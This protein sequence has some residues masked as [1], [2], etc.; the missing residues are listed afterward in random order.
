[1]SRQLRSVLIAGGSALALAMAAPAS[2]TDLLISP[3][4]EAE[5][6]LGGTTGNLA[7]WFQGVFGSY[8][9]EGGVD[10]S[11]NEFD[12]LAAGFGAHSRV[13]HD[14]GGGQGFQLEAIGD[15]HLSMASDDDDDDDDDAGA[16]WGAVGGHWI[17][18]ND[19][20]AHGVFAGLS[21]V[22][23]HTDVESAVH[24]FGGVEK[25]W[26]MANR[27]WFG[28]LGGAVVVDGEDALGSLVYG[29]VGHK[30]FISPDSSLE[31]T[32]LLGYA[33][34]YDTDCCGD[35]TALWLQFTAE[36]EHQWGHG[37]YS[38]FVGYQGDYVDAREDTDETVFVS[39]VKGGLRM[40]FGG[41]LY[42]ET[43]Y[44]SQTFGFA[45]MRAPMSYAGELN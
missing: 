27:M 28:Q 8:D 45:N 42:E 38:W 36:Y 21:G 29:R 33:P 10:E 22:A 31:L 39:T 43:H 41:N 3:Q 13:H 14:Y 26:F 19:S 6:A 17:S 44:G 23:H 7:V 16:A 32:G 9:R 30:H 20:S 24:A 2:A 4:S 25:A 40:T 18:R 11:D 5:R 12:N 34:D 15:F 35:D 1:M 37:P